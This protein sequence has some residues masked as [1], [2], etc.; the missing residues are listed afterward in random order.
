MNN[1][2]KKLKAYFHGSLKWV[3]S[4]MLYNAVI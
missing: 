1:K 3:L 4:F 2:F